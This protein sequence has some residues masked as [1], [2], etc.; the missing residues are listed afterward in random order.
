[1][2]NTFIS[3]VIRSEFYSYLDAYRYAKS[4]TVLEKS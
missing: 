2:C 1:M 3:R 4:M